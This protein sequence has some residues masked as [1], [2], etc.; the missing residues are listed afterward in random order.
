MNEGE[1]LDE[2]FASA[3][4]PELARVAWERVRD[5]GRGV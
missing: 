3:P 1:V 2:R 5:A 4:D